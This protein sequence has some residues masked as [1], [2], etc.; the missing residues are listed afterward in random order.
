MLSFVTSLAGL[1]VTSSAPILAYR[2]LFNRF[3]LSAYS[4]RLDF[5]V[6]K[7][8]EAL[9]LLSY[10]RLLL[11]FL[12]TL[13]LLR[14]PVLVAEIRS[15]SSFIARFDVAHGIEQLLD[16]RGGLWI[17]SHRLFGHLQTLVV[18]LK[19]MAPA[20]AVGG[21]GSGLDAKLLL[22]PSTRHVAARLVFQERAN[23][24]L[25]QVWNPVHFHN[26]NTGVPC[27]IRTCG[28]LVLQ[29]SALGFSANGTL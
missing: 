1:A 4:A 26:L 20:V 9:W 3:W 12:T 25:R 19:Q 18:H 6:Q 11:K 8:L 27:R 29:T 7:E 22:A 23:D 13:R 16:A 21:V 10:T 17:C 24:E 28:F 15:E 5:H 2:E 14:L